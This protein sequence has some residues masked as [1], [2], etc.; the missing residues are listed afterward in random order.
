[1]MGQTLLGLS[2]PDLA[3]LQEVLTGLMCSDFVSVACSS[4]LLCLA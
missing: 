4:V 2:T 3:G 1:M